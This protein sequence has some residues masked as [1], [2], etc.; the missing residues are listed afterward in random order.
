MPHDGGWAL[1]RDLPSHHAATI[2]GQVA[3]RSPREPAPLIEGHLTVRP[4]TVR[5]VPRG[6][7]TAATG[8]HDPA[9]PDP[10]DP[11]QRTRATQTGIAGSAQRRAI[12]FVFDGGTGVGHLRRLSCI[13]RQLQEPFSCLVVTGHR[14]AAHWF[15]PAECE[16]IHLPSWD[17][18]LQAKARY[19]NRQPFILLD[20]PDAVRLRREI[21]SAVVNA[22]QPDVIFI[23]DLPLGILDELADVLSDARCL[24]YL[25]TR[26][27]LNETDDVGRLIL[28]GRP[29]HYL[30]T[31]YDRI[32]VACD[33]KVFKFARQYNISA[34][35]SAKTSLLAMSWT[36]SCP[37]PYSAP[38]RLE[39]SATVTSGSSR[40]LATFSGANR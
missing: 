38:G 18:L 5:S 17:S 35:L 40:R 16:Y 37:A 32:L 4:V 10:R 12:F 28:G 19:W 31:H 1:G 20:E 27:V 34:D 36:A 33:Q 3:A 7:S 8:T 22:F 30:R 2:R 25:V 26:G 23:D 21:L 15:V 13:A 24:K 39:V 29:G 9:G 6:A 14:A 11:V